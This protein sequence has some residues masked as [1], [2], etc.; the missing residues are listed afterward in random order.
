MFRVIMTQK[1]SWDYIDAIAKRLGVKSEARRK[2]RERGSVPHRWR[3][4]ILQ[5]GGGLVAISD[6]EIPK[7]ENV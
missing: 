5:E 6:F 3:L 7:K 1:T 2:W 4:P